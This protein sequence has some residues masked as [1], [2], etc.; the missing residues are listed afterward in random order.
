M[1]LGVEDKNESVVGQGETREKECRRWR[2][3]ENK[4]EIMKS[5]TMIILDREIIGQMYLSR[6]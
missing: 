4:Y 3:E 1:G 2:Y 6:M 5:H